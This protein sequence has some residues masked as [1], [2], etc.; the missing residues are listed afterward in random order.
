MVILSNGVYWFSDKITY[1]ENRER[2]LIKLAFLDKITYIENR[3]RHLIHSYNEN[4]DST[5]VKVGLC[6]HGITGPDPGPGKNRNQVNQGWDLEESSGFQE[7][8]Q[9][10]KFKIRSPFQDWVLKCSDEL[11]GH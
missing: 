3:E 6:F 4:R 11:Q 10:Q 1:I 2:H 8:L 9:Y 7:V 5:E